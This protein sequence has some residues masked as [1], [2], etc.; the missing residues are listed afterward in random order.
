MNE[1]IIFEFEANIEPLENHIQDSECMQSFWL[2]PEQKK[3]FEYLQTNKR[4]YIDV[5]EDLGLKLKKLSEQYNLEFIAHPACFDW[6]FFKCYYE[7]AKLNSK[8]KEYFYDIGFKCL[9]SSTLWNYYKKINKLSSKQANDLF[10]NLGEYDDDSNHV[11]IVDA[12]VQGKFYV[13]L[14]KKMSYC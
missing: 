13:K 11:A 8:N 4:N 1:N 10:K 12:K 3:A 14:L 9:C 7:L 5:F 6:M 2:K